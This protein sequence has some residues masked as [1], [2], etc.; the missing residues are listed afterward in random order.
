MKSRFICL[1]LAGIFLAFVCHGQS[2]QPGLKIGVSLPDIQ[3]NSEQS[4]VYASR[5]APFFGIS[6]TKKIS[7]YFNL[8]AEINYSPQGG[9]RDGMQPVDAIKFGMP[10]GTVL[11]ANYRNE[12]KLD[13]LEIPVLIQLY[14]EKPQSDNIIFYF[15]NFGPFAAFRLNAET[16][17]SG[18][19]PIYLD[20]EGTT[21]FTKDGIPSSAQSF[22]SNTDI[23]EQIKTTN[24]GFIGGI[25][26]GYKF[27]SHKFFIEARLTRGL[28]NFQSHTNNNEKSKTGSLIFAAGYIYSFQ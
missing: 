14:G 20:K 22:N 4:K 23:K 26:S 24:A 19:S 28:T 8:Q 13:Y 2:I 6:L 10:E 11:Y 17:T 15:A 9:K 21:V 3:G 12:I 1:A 18:T 16:A 5:W 25:G 7:S 27:D